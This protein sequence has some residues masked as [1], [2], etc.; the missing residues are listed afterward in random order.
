M[1]EV[2]IPHERFF[3][4]STFLAYCR[5]KVSF[6]VLFKG[7]MKEALGYGRIYRRNH[8][9]LTFIGDIKSKVHRCH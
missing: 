4:S 2:K 6:R 1:R 7:R 8:D 3:V 9:N 5:Q